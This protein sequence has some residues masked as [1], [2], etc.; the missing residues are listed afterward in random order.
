MSH[1][2]SLARTKGPNARTIVP[3][4]QSGPHPLGR[5][6]SYHLQKDGLRAVVR[7]VL[8]R[9]GRAGLLETLD[10]TADTLCFYQYSE[11][12][13]RAATA[14]ADGRGGCMTVG[15]AQRTVEGIIKLWGVVKD[16]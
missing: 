9:G 10:R 13:Y 14:Q 15:I 5:R 3:Y 6:S 11:I 2:S 1:D 12:N 8:P 16:G 7:P 4:S